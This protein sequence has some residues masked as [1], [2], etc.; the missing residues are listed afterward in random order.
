MQLLC[1]LVCGDGIAGAVN[2]KKCAAEPVCVPADQRAEVGGALLI[3][4]NIIKSKHDIDRSATRI[5]HQ[6]ALDGGAV[7]ENRHGIAAAVL[8]RVPGDRNAGFGFAK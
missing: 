1:A 6:N 4:G 2:L 3:A 7:I 5:R 8:Q